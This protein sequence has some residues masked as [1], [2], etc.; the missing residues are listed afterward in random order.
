MQHS[1]RFFA[2]GEVQSLFRAVRQRASRGTL[3]DKVDYALVTFA[4]ATGCRA[5]EI[6]SVSLDPK[7]VNYLDV[8]AGLV[9]LT[10]AKWGSSGTVPLDARSL[11]VMRRY[12]REVRPLVRNAAVLDRLFLT[13]TG[14]PYTPN[15]MSKKLTMLLTRYGFPGKTAHSFRHHFCTDLLRRGAHLHE[16]KALMRHRDVRSTM[17]YSHATVDDLR[18]AVNRR[19][20]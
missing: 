12:V 5:S 18:A 17:L 13:K 16:A 7:Q 15:T 14:S 3:L 19:V 20:G 10:D 11:R 8:R 9:V 2:D 6:A 1:N 4:W